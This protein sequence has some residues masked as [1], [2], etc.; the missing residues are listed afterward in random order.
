[1]KCCICKKEIEVKGTWNKGNNANPV[2]DG[3]CCD[4]CDNEIVI[5]FRIKSFI[6]DRIRKKGIR[7][8]KQQ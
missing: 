6:K 3:R 4:K 8:D 7:N 2:K 5:P 1:M